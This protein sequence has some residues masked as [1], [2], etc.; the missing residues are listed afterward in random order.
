MNHLHI[1]TPQINNRFFSSSSFESTQ[2]IPHGTFS[3]QSLDNKQLTK[4]MLLIRHT[5][6]SHTVYL[7]MHKSFMGSL[8]H[9]HIHKHTYVCK[10]VCAFIFYYLFLFFSSL[11][12]LSSLCTWL[13]Y[14]FTFSVC[15]SFFKSRL[16]F[17]DSLSIDDKSVNWKRV[18]THAML[19][20]I[21]LFQCDWIKI[22]DLPYSPVN[23]RE[24][25]VNVEI[26][27]Q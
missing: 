5:D 16:F 25:K 2:T 6:N 8:A 10:A 4:R 19:Y 26:H 23:V 22:D 3:H 13:F 27:A 18:H 9:T 17:Y 20:W 7:S 21:S 14:F 12:A 11:P 15:F 1:Y 24:R